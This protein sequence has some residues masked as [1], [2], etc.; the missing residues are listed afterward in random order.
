MYEGI[1]KLKFEDIYILQYHGKIIHVYITGK[2]LLD[3][4]YVISPKLVPENKVM[5][6]KKQDHCPEDCT[7]LSWRQM[8]I[9]SCKPTFLAPTTDVK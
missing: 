3:L 2:H 5:C 9:K 4:S 8:R 6:N 7:W 1:S